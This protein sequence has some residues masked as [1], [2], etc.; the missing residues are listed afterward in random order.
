MSGLT[1]WLGSWVE[2]LE[3][4]NY[5]RLSGTESILSSRCEVALSISS[6]VSQRSIVLSDKVEVAGIECRL[7]CLLRVPVSFGDI[8]V[9]GFFSCFVMMATTSVLR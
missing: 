5:F 6:S 7:C 4:L 1:P 3:F 9:H 8:I 2:A